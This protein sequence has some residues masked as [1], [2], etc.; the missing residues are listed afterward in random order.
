MSDEFRFG[1]TYAAERP[2]LMMLIFFVSVAMLI[3]P[4]IGYPLATPLSLASS[5]EAGA[6]AVLTCFG[7]GWLA[8]SLLLAAWGGPAPRMSGILGPLADGVFE[9]FLVD[10]GALAGSIDAIIGVG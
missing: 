9:P 4:R 6:A 2:P 3:I 1:V 8:A 5:D 10:G 7:V